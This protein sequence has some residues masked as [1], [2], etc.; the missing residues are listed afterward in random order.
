MIETKRAMIEAFESS[1]KYKL[2]YKK[3]LNDT[4]VPMVERKIEELKD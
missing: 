3:E 1:Q 4:E 2:I